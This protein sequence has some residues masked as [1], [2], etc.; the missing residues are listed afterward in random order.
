MRINDE[1]LKLVNGRI[2]ALISAGSFYGKKL[3]EAGITKVESENNR[4]NTSFLRIGNIILFITIC[5]TFPFNAIRYFVVLSIQDKAILFPEITMTTLQIVASACSAFN[6]SNQIEISPAIK[7]RNN[8]KYVFLL[9]CLNNC[10][11]S[12]S[13]ECSNF[14][15]I[16][17]NTFAYISSSVDILESILLH[18]FRSFSAFN[19]P[20]LI[21]IA[22]SHTFSISVRS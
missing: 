3:S 19:S 12:Q 8:K 2:E 13:K 10:F 1:Q 18:L 9:L 21:K 22:L 14:I 6:L 17:I 15:I 16:Y 20:F 5:F 11:S 7:H 4:V